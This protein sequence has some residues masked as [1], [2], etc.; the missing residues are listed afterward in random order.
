MLVFIAHSTRPDKTHLLNWPVLSP[1]I[2]QHHL[3]SPQG[4]IQPAELPVPELVQV[5]TRQAATADLYS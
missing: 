5:S 3:P 1:L 4:W 2:V